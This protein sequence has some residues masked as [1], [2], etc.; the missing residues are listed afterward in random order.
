MTI[1]PPFT[2]Y[3]RSV[4]DR[5]NGASNALPSGKPPFNIGPNRQTF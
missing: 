3:R 5:A 2:G 1:A 4:L